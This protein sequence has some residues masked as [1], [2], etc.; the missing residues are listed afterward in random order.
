VIAAATY[1]LLGDG[2]RA[3]PT[4]PLRLK[5][6]SG[7]IDA[8]VLIDLPARPVGSGENREGGD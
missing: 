2:V 3:T 5:G 7:A 6:K 8:W 4:G 1:A